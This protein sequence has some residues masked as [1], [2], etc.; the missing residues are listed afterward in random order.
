MFYLEPSISVE[1][2]SSYPVEGEKVVYYC[3]IIDQANVTALDL[4]FTDNDESPYNSET[5]ISINITKFE[6]K[7]SFSLFFRSMSVILYFSYC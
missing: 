1:P 7:H 5:G 3:I 4:E 6:G 2:E